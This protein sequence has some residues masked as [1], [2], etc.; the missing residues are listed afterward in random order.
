MARPVFA[1]FCNAVCEKIRFRPDRPGVY[2]E[3]LAHLQDSAALLEEEEGMEG[4]QAAEEAVKRMGDAEEIGI[5]LD[6]AHSPLLG[7]LWIL[8]KWFLGISLVLAFFALWPIDELRSLFYWP[9]PE[10]LF[11][12][13]RK[14]I[15]KQGGPSEK[16]R[17]GAYTFQI[18]EATLQDTWTPDYPDIYTGNYGPEVWQ[19]LELNI[20]LRSYTPL[21]YLDEPNLNSFL[22]L[23]GSEG[24]VYLNSWHPDADRSQ[25]LL[26]T[27]Y[28]HPLFFW[29]EYRLSMYVDYG[30][31][32]EFFKNQ[33]LDLVYE[34][35]GNTF[36]IRIP[37]E[38]VTE[39]EK[40]S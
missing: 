40:T 36:R 19:T 17:L 34:R 12:A 21:F 9:W 5:L 31:R 18:E 25:P 38:E 7:W 11:Y 2:E 27:S 4:A 8:S 16:V 29:R 28:S 26:Q 22:S 14:E 24:Q 33:W 10:E 39:H 15:L 32:E 30:Q 1:R 35:E 20:T 23:E 6:K 37:L 13:D 3:L